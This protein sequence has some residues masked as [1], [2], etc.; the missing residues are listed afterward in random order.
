[1]RQLRIIIVVFILATFGIFVWV[2]AGTSTEAL[3]F[4]KMTSGGQSLVLLV[5][6]VCAF[7]LLSTLAGLPVLYLSVALGFLLP[8]L[9]ALGICW[10]VNFLAVMASYY[11]VRHAFSGYF[12]SRYGGKKLIK[13]I[14]KR[15]RKYGIWPVV[16]SR[17]IYIIPT[18]LIN[19][20]FP[21]SQIST[22]SYA[23][24][25]VIGLVPE[26]L[27]N[28]VTGMLIRKGVILISSPE[29]Q[30][31]QVLAV[32]GFILL[33]ATTFILLR[34]RQNRIRKFRRLKAIPYSDPGSQN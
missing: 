30:L 26:C 29:P 2:T 20:S 17:A 23:L 28:V 19:F 24:G 27:V 16:F 32:A 14:N 4:E 31:W 1:M 5:L 21:L 22:R 18:S 11:M 6:L 13:R 9:P 3:V 25:T 12:A 8:F 34:L 15:I 10:A 7:T 33:F